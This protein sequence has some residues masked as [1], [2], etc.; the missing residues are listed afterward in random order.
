MADIAGLPPSFMRVFAWLVVCDPPEQ[1][2]SDMQDA[3]GLS[4][5]AISTATTTLT[6]MAV[7]ERVHVAGERRLYYRLRAGGWERLMRYRLEATTQM[8]LIADKALERAPARQ[9]RLEEMRDLYA[10]FEQ[11]LADVLRE[12]S[13]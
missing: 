11:A 6:R 7:V 9:R 3:L 8:R 4:S 12:H 10:W 13:R 2:V 1:S 5:G